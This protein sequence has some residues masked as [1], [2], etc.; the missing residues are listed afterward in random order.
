M[1]NHVKEFYCQ[2]SDGGQRGNFFKAIALSE[3]AGLTWEEVH[4]M[5]PSIC[6]GWYELSKL[7][8]RD[9]IEFTRDF[10]LSKLPYHQK[11]VENIAQFF[12][13]LDNLHVFIVQKSYD[14]PYEA[15][16][17]YCLKNDQGFFHGNHGAS[18]EDIVRL[19]KDFP[20]IIFPQD[21]LSFLQI[22]NGFCKATDTGILP[23]RS[24]KE[25]TTRF[26]QML[27]AKPVINERGEIFNPTSLIPFYESFGMP[28]FQCF[29]TDWYPDQ[30]MGN[31]Y[32]SG[33]TNTISEIDYDSLSAET[34]AF[35]TFL[36]WLYFY[37][38]R[39]A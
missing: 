30:E 16:L 17:V 14:D 1:D 12:D 5:V 32:Y 31:V 25:S 35:P 18:E 13:S 38:E 29:Y 33:I 24:L 3:N 27:N 22:H 36:D 8:A 39:V 6:K 10:W 21:Y 34:L 19:Q 2:A 20:G 7:P 9:R 37:L 15:H 28:V 26:R 11:I 23:T 4:K